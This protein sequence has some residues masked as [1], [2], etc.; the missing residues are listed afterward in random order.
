M[1]ETADSVTLDVTPVTITFPLPNYATAA[2]SSA[3]YADTSIHSSTNV[4]AINPPLTFTTVN[5]QNVDLNGVAYS[6]LNVS[7]IGADVYTKSESD[8]RYL[9]S[10]SFPLPNYGVLSDTTTYENT[11]VHSSTNVLS[12]L[13]PLT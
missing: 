9:Q 11:T 10:V 1:A 2:S 12:F 7:H 13:A 6:S 3:T 5:H 4:L 8:G